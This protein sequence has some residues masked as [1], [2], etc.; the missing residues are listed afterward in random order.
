MKRLPLTFWNL[1]RASRSW[2]RGKDLFQV[3]TAGDYCKGCT[4][5]DWYGVLGKAPNV[6]C[7]MDIDRQGFVDLLV[8]AQ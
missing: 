5:G 7:I 3:E 4:V 6:S 8:E 2:E 1:T